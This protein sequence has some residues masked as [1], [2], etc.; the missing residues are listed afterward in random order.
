M[1]ELA[2]GVPVPARLTPAELAEARRLYPEVDLDPG[3]GRTLTAAAALER[4]YQAADPLGRALVQAAVDWR[5]TG[6]T[7]P[8]SE[9]DLGELARA[10]LPDPDPPAGQEAE[11]ECP[12]DPDPPAGGPDG[13]GGLAWACEPVAPGVALLRRTGRRRPRRFVP[14]GQLVALAEGAGE[15]LAG[16]VHPAAWALAMA[17]A[18]PRDAARI[19]FAAYAGGDFEAAAAAWSKAASGHP[20]LAPEAAVALG[21]LR[22]HLGDPEGAAAAF[23]AAAASGHAEANLDGDR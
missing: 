21:L 14:A 4:R 20:L 3:I 11:A 1:L 19:G 15:G 10:Y 2:A 22:R 5:R 23:Q 7:V 18:T 17:R 16:A 12:A 9:A 6:A 13:V 8:I